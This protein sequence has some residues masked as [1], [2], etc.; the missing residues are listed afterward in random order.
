[1]RNLSGLTKT[2]IYILVGFLFS[3]GILFIFLVPS[4][5]LS[6]VDI[7]RFFLSPALIALIA[8]TFGAWMG[9]KSNIKAS[10]ADLAQTYLSLLDL[11]KEDIRINMR[12]MMKVQDTLQILQAQG[13][14]PAAEELAPE[15]V[16]TMFFEDIEFHKLRQLTPDTM[17]SDIF[18]VRTMRYILDQWNTLVS[19]FYREDNPALRE[20]GKR[21]II[22]H[23]TSD[24]P[25]VNFI[26]TCK[27]ALDSI[28]LMQ[29]SIVRNV[30]KSV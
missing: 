19:K 12:I 23:L 17:I 21:E 7:L 8:A 6:V 1:M 13:R 3:L 27:R 4:G 26:E 16:H 9:A 28:D 25:D 11:M 30:L 24:S 22:K 5:K 20:E 14:Q 10:Q 18:N 15:S 29:S 2:F